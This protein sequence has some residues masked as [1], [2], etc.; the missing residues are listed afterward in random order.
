MV[1]QGFE[2]G[3]LIEFI[4]DLA[5]EIMDVEHLAGPDDFDVDYVAMLELE[6]WTARCTLSLAHQSSVRAL[7]RAAAYPTAQRH[8]PIRWQ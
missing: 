7:A 6:P 5:A 4:E 1:Q 2:Q 8:R 3:A